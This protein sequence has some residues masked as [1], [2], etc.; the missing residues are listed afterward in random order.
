MIGNDVKNEAISNLN[1]EIECNKLITTEVNDGALE[2]HELRAT[3]PSL[4]I[5]PLEIFINQFATSPKELKK[6]F[7]E[8]KSN[9]RIFIENVNEFNQKAE[10][11]S[12][13]AGVGATAG[14]AIGAGTTAIMPSA[15]M[16]FATTFG[17][18]STGAAISSLSGAAATNAALAWL[19][20]GTVAAGSGGV[21]GGT[22]FLALAGPIGIG[23]GLLGI[24]AGALF[25][26]GKNKEIAAEANNRLKE[27]KK[28]NNMLSLKKD[29]LINL[30]QLTK[31]H[32]DG[33]QHLL[34]ELKI[35]AENY[36]P[37]FAKLKRSWFSRIV[38]W[39]VN[40]LG[41]STLPNYKKFSKEDKLKLAAL[42]NHVESFSELLNQKV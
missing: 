16:A 28:I 4:I 8:C 10:D 39:V 11:A 9:F 2:L 36:R 21:A 27:I 18:A 26:N 29:N 5:E 23:I 25:L 7:A 19:G 33:I 40:W 38:N 20:G 12:F 13:K 31:K 17:T 32:G 37:W 6:V 22:A 14:V 1:K 34:E 15:A 41:I 30:L 3:A 24:G 35:N 42:I